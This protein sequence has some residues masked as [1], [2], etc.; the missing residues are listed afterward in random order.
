MN[1]LFRKM[2][3]NHISIIV[4]SEIGVKFYKDLGFTEI[5]RTARLSCHDELIYLS[6]GELVLE[7]Y[8]DATHPKRVTNPE[9][10]GLRHLCFTVDHIE[11]ECKTDEKGRFAFIYDPDGLPIELREQSYR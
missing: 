4:S 10:Y 2:T 9:A 5:S 1:P 6:N 3:L 7:L 11:G 8:K